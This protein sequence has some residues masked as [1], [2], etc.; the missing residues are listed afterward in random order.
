MDET[1]KQIE[2]PAADDTA[3]PLALDSLSPPPAPDAD[4]SSSEDPLALD[5]LGPIRGFGRWT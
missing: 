5:P 2:T 3:S 1:T 4:T